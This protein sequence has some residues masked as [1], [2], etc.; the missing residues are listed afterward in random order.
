LLPGK[1]LAW[2]G[3]FVD[4]YT[5]DSPAN[6]P[7]FYAELEKVNASLPAGQSIA[8]IEIYSNHTI[9]TFIYYTF[10]GRSPLQHH[11]TIEEDAVGKKMILKHKSWNGNTTVAT[12]AFL[13]SIDKYFMDPQGI[14]VKAESFRLF[15]SDPVYTF[16]S[17]SSPF[18]MTTWKLN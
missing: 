13:A 8:S 2:F 9:G 14:Y 7:L 10:V 12:P 18:R 6:S 16:T 15:Y 5:I 11:V 1:P 4:D 3:F 17:A